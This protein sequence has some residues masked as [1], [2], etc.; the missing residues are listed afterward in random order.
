[1]D[2]AAVLGEAVAVVSRGV[3]NVARVDASGGELWKDAFLRMP[4]ATGVSDLW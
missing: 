2:V 4:I 3:S 1:M